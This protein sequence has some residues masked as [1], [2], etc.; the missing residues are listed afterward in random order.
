MALCSD[1]PKIIYTETVDDMS[2]V[3]FV[4]FGVHMVKFNDKEWKSCDAECPYLGNHP[5]RPAYG[6]NLYCKYMF[7]PR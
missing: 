2:T 3:E 6:C 4:H 7:K 5:C 1:N